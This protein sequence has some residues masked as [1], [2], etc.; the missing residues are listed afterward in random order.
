MVASVPTLLTM[1]CKAIPDLCETFGPLRA[2]L[3]TPVEEQVAREVYGRSPS[4]DFSREV[5]A[6]RP[7][8]LAVLPVRG[9]EWT[10]LGDPRRALATRVRVGF[11]RERVAWPLAELA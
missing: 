1:T 6:A 9:V 3:G 2:V 10:D 11:G 8:N 7:P 5:L 4:R